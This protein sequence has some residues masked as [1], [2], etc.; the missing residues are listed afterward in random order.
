ME[1]WKAVTQMEGLV[2][3]LLVVREGRLDAAAEELQVNR[4]TVTR[5]LKAL[6]AALGGRVVVRGP[7]GMEVTPL[8]EEALAAAR[9][10]SKPP[11]SL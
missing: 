6:E 5:R 3:L 2:T 8:G 10:R 4:T 1:R 9:A 11:W 7:A